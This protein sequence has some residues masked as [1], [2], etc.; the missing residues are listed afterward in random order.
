MNMM[1]IMMMMM[2]TKYFVSWVGLEW[3]KDPKNYAGGRLLLVGSPLPDRS[4]EKAQTKRG[5]LVIQVGG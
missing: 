4:K 2:M 5:T 3:P 1:M